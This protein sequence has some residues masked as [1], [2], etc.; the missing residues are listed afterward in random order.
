MGRQHN[1]QPADVARV[2]QQMDTEVDFEDEFI[3]KSVSNGTRK[4]YDSQINWLKEVLNTLRE[5]SLTK[6][7]FFKILHVIQ[8]SY[9]GHKAEMLRSA[10][11][12]HIKSTQEWNTERHWLE[13]HD[14]IQ[15]CQG[16]R[17]Q[18]GTTT[19]RGQATPEGVKALVKNLHKVGQTKYVPMV[20]LQY[21]AALRI[22]ELKLIRAGD[23][24]ESLRRLVIRT[25]KRN[26]RFR[27]H[28]KSDRKVTKTIYDDRAHKVLVMMQHSLPRGTDLFPKES[29][30]VTKYRQLYKACYPP[31]H[32]DLSYVPH[33]LRHGGVA[34]ILQAAHTKEQRAEGTLQS[35]RMQRYYARSNIQ[36]LQQL[37]R[38][39]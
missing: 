8:G 17:Y 9:E 15:A 7:L 10:A 35:E 38:H 31:D 3:L 12:F 22:S 30:P 23:Y 28:R 11:L 20:L 27:N 5:E 18:N 13:H 4:Q 34:Q 1:V 24:D 2:I 19:N 14:T 37:R 36:R 32:P 26:T 39:T 21:G 16:F 29:T 6:D 33:S 25:D